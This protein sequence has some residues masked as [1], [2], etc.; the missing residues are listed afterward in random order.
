MIDSIASMST[1]MSQVQLRNEVSMRVL[2]MAQGQ[3]QATAQL[4]DATLE[5]LQ[6]IISGM[7][8]GLGGGVDAYG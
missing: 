5:N 4:L 2:K 6:E 1:A 7:A 3:D 8:E